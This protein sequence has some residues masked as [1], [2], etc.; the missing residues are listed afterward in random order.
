MVTKVSS[1]MQSYHVW[2]VV[3]VG[4]VTISFDSFFSRFCDYSACYVTPILSTI[5][6]LTDYIANPLL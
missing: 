1:K 3:V 5:V 6:F 2:N 4:S